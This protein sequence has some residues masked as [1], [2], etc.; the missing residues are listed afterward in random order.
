MRFLLSNKSLNHPDENFP[1]KFT[2]LNCGS[3]N[4]IT[5]RG[6]CVKK[7]NNRWY[8]NQGYLRDCSSKKFSVAEHEV[9]SMNLLF[10]D[11]PLD[12]LITG[13]FSSVICDFN[14]LNLVL[15]NDPIG[16]Y[17]IYYYIKEESFYISNSKILLGNFLNPELD[18]TGI[19][20]RTTLPEYSEIGSRTILKGCRRL[21]PGEW[22][23]LNFKNFH[24]EKKYDNTLFN[25]K[26]DTEN[27]STE[28]YWNL[29]ETEL[30]VLLQDRSEVDLAL[31]GGMDSRILFGAIP[32]DK[33]INCI[34]YG[35]EDSYEV[36][37]AKKLSRKRRTTFKSFSSFLMNF[38][39]REILDEYVR[40]T[41]AVY[42]CSWLEILESI[43]KKKETALLLG[44]LS[45]ALT[46]RSIKKFSSRAYQKKNF[47][48]HSIFSVDYEL[49]VNNLENFE[50][51]K[52]GVLSYYLN[53]NNSKTIKD[54][55][56]EIT[57]AELVDNIK[58]DL[59]ELFLRIQS[60]E[61]DYIEQV[62]ELFIWYTHTRNPMGK[63]V[64]INNYKFKSYCPGLSMRVLRFSSSLHP[65]DRLN[66]RFIDK[67]NQQIPI[68]KSLSKLPTSQ[69]PL[70]PQTFSNFIRFPVWALRSKI[71]H[72][73]ISKAV[74]SGNVSGR[75]RLFSANNWI[76]IYQ[77]AELENILSDYFENGHLGEAFM[78]EV[79]IKGKERKVL[80][81]W[82]FANMDIINSAALNSEIDQIL[83]KKL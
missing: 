5:D 81:R 16:I 19:I 58:S 39:S 45:T 55:E 33:L 46:A 67:L 22:I 4:L 6:E 1:K 3:I 42:L 13:S 27:N 61:L 48:K 74:R 10:E 28:E 29:L 59:D 60:H 9:N 11:W 38:P 26:V 54:R 57:R 49:E 50:K 64:L 35:P 14:Q 72:F 12:N 78:N 34:T 79:K 53:F 71:D 52:K 36:A 40:K 37:I 62:E 41:E 47:I 24:I 43:E 69:I 82:P 23:K 83:K 44:D 56:L 80:K 17:P 15:C 25:F 70:I 18:E 51:W 73:L 32:G 7:V 65:N 31:S 66:N 30:E 2:E 68:L 75:Y 21:L 8:L 20:E 76:K 77:N 63:Q